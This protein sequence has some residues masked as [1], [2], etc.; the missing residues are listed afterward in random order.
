[1]PRR[2][3]CSG[4]PLSSQAS[5]GVHRQSSLVKVRAPA[6]WILASARVHQNIEGVRCWV[7]NENPAAAAA[8]DFEWMNAKRIAQ[9]RQGQNGHRPVQNKWTLEAL[10]N[11]RLVLGEIGLARPAKRSRSSVIKLL[12]HRC[13]PS[14]QLMTLVAPE[15]NHLKHRRHP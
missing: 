14:Q 6:S 12:K 11:D 8:F 4:I 5:E 15:T 1:M 2:P 9:F 13:R 7:E 10:G 3:S